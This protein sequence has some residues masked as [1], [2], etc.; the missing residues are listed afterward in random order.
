ME[1]IFCKHYTVV[2]VENNIIVGF[3]DIDKTVYFDRLFV[4][5]DYQNQGIASDYC[6]CRD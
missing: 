6:K 3:G 5:K 2:A 1:Q 4:H